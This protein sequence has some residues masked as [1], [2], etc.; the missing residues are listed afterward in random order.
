MKKGNI[1]K[2]KS[3]QLIK[4][5]KINE[6]IL[7]VKKVVTNIKTDKADYISLFGQF[8]AVGKEFEINRDQVTKN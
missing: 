5:L 8:Q 3:G 7:I 6:N 2:L 4:I 1:V